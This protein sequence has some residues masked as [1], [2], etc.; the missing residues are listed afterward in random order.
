M[1]MQSA[2]DPSEPDGS[3]KENVAQPPPAARTAKPAA[4]TYRRRLP[5][6]QRPH[7]PVFVTFV[8]VNRMVLPSGAR[9]LVLQ[10][11][12]HDHPTKLQMHAAVVMPDH[13]HLLFTPLRD[14]AGAFYSLREIMGGIK[15]AS[16][17]SVNALLGRKGRLWQKESFDHVL[18]IAEDVRATA[19]YVAANAVSA[20]LVDVEDEYPWLWRE[21]V[22][23]AADCAS[24]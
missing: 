6:I 9:D 21:W 17:H 20:G 22:E 13:V 23:G 12:L 3:H 2:S 8:T 15:G 16:S 4:Q 18:R 11:C 1:A 19:E 10:H 14:G 7:L 24:P 5:H